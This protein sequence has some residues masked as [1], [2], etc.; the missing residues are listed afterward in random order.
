MTGPGR[1]APPA[2]AHRGVEHTEAGTSRRA[3]LL[4]RV[5]D[6]LLEQGIADLTLR[7]VSA[8]V[9]SNNR[10]LL[11]Y[12]GSREQLIETALQAAS[13]RFPTMPTLLDVLDDASR[14]VPERLVAVWAD[15]AD[16]QLLPYHRLFF[17]VFGL[18][19]FAPE[20]FTSLLD[21]VGTEWVGRVTAALT[22]DGLPPRVAETLAHEVV[23]LWRGLQATLIST[24]DRAAVDRA[25]AGGI[26]ALWAGARPH[27][28]E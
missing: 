9:G 5:V 18:A 1:T 13:F 23:A 7:R 10:M 16:P 25:A 24:G 21:A 2:T 8:A 11:Y 6:H 19:G 28:T 17:Q 4:E 26:A 3:E 12:F 14:P 22:A 15:L 27:P 20:R